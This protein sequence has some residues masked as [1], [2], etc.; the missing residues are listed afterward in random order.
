MRIKG[1]RFT[2]LLPAVVLAVM[3]VYVIPMVFQSHVKAM[4]ALIAAAFLISVP[5]YLW[6]KRTRKPNQVSSDKR[7]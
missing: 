1:L 5:P 2:T 7:P 3:C 6:K 4:I